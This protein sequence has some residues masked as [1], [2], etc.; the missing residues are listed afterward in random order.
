LVPVGYYGNSFLENVDGSVALGDIDGDGFDEKILIN[1][2]NLEVYSFTNNSDVFKSGFP[3]YGEFTGFPLVSDILNNDGTPEII[4]KNHDYISFISNNG[5]TIYNIPLFNNDAE[6]FIIPEW[7]DANSRVL[8]NGD[9]LYIFDCTLSNCSNETNFWLNPFSTPELSSVVG[10]IHEILTQE[11]TD[12]GID[13]SRI[14]NY[15]N[16]IK[17]GVTKFRFFVYDSQA[18]TIRIY[19][20][21]GYL[22]ETLFSEN[23]S[24]NTY[25]EIVWSF[26]SISP[27]LYL[28]EI[29]SDRNE[30]KLIKV[31]VL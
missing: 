10:G 21:S 19:D 15:P 3:V 26:N 2:G 18:V 17:D 6:L 27:G 1:N 12:K 22:I 14:Y 7:G 4:V 24:L 28:A 30:R 11:T 8:A 9:F 16:P 29:K 20:T 23:L 13:I 25:N 5:E 31:V